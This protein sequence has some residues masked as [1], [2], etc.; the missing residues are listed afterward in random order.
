ML[1]IMRVKVVDTFAYEELVHNE[2]LCILRYE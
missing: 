1:E 2:L